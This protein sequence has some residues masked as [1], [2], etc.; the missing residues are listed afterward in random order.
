MYRCDFGDQSF[1][2]WDGSEAKDDF[3]SVLAAGE[4]R[5]WQSESERERRAKHAVDIQRGREWLPEGI[6]RSG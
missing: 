1:R 5:G 6:P 2:G 3:P 4:K